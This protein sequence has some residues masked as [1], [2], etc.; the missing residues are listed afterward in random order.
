MSQ[1][2]LCKHEVIPCVVQE[3]VRQENYEVTLDQCGFLMAD[4]TNP[5]GIW[6]SEVYHERY[7]CPACQRPLTGEQVRTMLTEPAHTYEFEELA[8]YARENVLRR[9]QKL[10]GETHVSDDIILEIINTNPCSRFY[11]DGTTAPK[12]SAT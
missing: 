10:F 6:D 11:A 8:N 4:H 1:C 2:P 3:M 12:E 9:F 5:R 7:F